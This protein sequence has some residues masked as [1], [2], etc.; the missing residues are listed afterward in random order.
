MLFDMTTA[1]SDLLEIYEINADIRKNIMDNIDRTPDIR[2]VADPQKGK[3]TVIRTTK[4]QEAGKAKN[5]AIDSMKEAIGS[6]ELFINGA[7]VTDIHTLDAASRI[8]EPYHDLPADAVIDS[9]RRQDWKVQHSVTMD[10]MYNKLTTILPIN[11]KFVK[12]L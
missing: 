1:L 4:M 2:N 12:G 9:G 5:S 10:S 8:N 7:H 3:S 11:T 6:A